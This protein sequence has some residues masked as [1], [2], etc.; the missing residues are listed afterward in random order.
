VG[1]LNIYSIVPLEPVKI[2]FSS[3]RNGTESIEVAVY[4]YNVVDL[5]SLN[6][7]PAFQGRL[8]P[9]SGL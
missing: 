9:E 4:F 3:F 7:D 8:D 6:P 1:T 5:D 2:F